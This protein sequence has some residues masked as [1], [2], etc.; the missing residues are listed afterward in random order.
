LQLGLSAGCDAAPWKADAKATGTACLAYTWKEGGDNIYVCANSINDGNYAYDN[1]SAYYLTYFHKFNRR[2]HTGTEAWY[3]YEKHVPNVNNPVGSTMVRTNANGAIC[4]TVAQVTCFAP[5]WS[6][7]NYTN[8]QLDKHDFVSLRNEFLN[9]MRGQRTG[10]R[11]T[12]TE[13]GLSW[14]HWV[15]TT[16]LFRPEVRFER[17][18]GAMA[19]DGG[20]RHNQF[21]LAGD[22]LWFF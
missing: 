19:Y 17:S 20:H 11:S 21:M 10:Y 12:F 14:N 18:Y 22:M 16:V 2:W 5:D 13:H 3:Q 7:L 6:V 1:L 4:N 15:G 8:L 9:D